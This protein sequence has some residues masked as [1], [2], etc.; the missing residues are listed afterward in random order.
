MPAAVRIYDVN[1]RLVRTLLDQSL[2][3]G[4]HVAVWDGR[5]AAGRSAAAG[6][7]YYR[8]EGG[9][10]TATRSMVLVK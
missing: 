9:P 10:Y 8:V 2:A 6:I 3:A 5:G 4:D 7:Y 1:G